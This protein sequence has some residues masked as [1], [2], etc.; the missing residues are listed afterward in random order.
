MTT[1]EIRLPYAASQTLQ[2]AFPEM[3]AVQIATD[4]T[5]LIGDLRDQSELHGLI[6]RLGDMGLEI[7]EVRQE[8]MHS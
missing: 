4:I 3:K 8:P 1:Y 6:A 2:D 7:T 5:L